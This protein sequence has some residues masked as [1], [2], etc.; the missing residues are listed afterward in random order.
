MGDIDD[1]REF[2]WPSRTQ[3]KIG[4]WAGVAKYAEVRMGWMMEG[5]SLVGEE[6]LGL[7]R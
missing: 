3:M 4:I 2:S 7:P 1:G 6:S 5:I